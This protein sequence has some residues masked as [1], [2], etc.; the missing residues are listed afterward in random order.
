MKIFIILSLVFANSLVSF[1]QIADNYLDESSE[2]KMDTTAVVNTGAPAPKL[3]INCLNARCHTDYLRTKLSFFDF[4]RDR[5]VS[6]IE[7]LV[8]STY[9]GAGGQQYVLAFYG[10]DKFENIND[11][12]YF[13][14]NKTDT[15]DLVRR[16]LVRTIKQ[17]LIRYLL[18]T[19]FMEQIGITLPDRKLKS[20]QSE[21]R[22][23]RWKRW[24]F[25]IGGDGSARGESNK[26]Y[27]SFS[28]HMQANR[29]T[30]ESKFSFDTHYDHNQ[31]QFTVSGENI[32]V[33]TVNYGVSSLYVKSFSE[34]WSAGGFYNAYHSIYRNIRLSQSLAPAIEYSFFPVSDVTRR[35]FRSIY[36]LG[37][38]SYH[39]IEPTIYD[40]IQENLPYHQLSGIF[41][42]TQPWGTLGAHLTA[43]QYLHDLS[44]NRLSVDFNLSWRVIEGLSIRVNGQASLINNQI[45]LARSTIDPEQ[46]LLN[47]R[48]LPTS[49][50]Y[51]SSLGLNYTFGSIDNSVVNPRFSNVH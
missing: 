22:K 24:V 18:D 41:G 25:N 11:T 21:Q 9:T 28:T 30:P 44:K 4:V 38:R 3:F 14:T 39:Y 23:D 35:Q 45:S 47:G 29:I 34:H 7:I 12:L 26:Q 33:Q 15:D 10:H 5:Y 16:Q 20:R 19:D 32:S 2:S 17:G 37:I 13:N 6:D 31:S 46:V 36:Q 1:A 49:F 43:Y 40:K 42:V 48:Q 50:N 51:Y 27:L 8:T